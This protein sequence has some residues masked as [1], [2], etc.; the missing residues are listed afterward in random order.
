MHCGWPAALPHL[1]IAALSR[2]Y[3]C[4]R[5]MLSAIYLKG[6]SMTRG[7][8]AVESAVIRMRARALSDKPVE[9]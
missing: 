3:L 2:I 7:I 1:K 9:P 5:G 4:A 6:G 8:V